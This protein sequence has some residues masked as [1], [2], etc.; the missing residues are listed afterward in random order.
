MCIALKIKILQMC[1]LVMFV[2]EFDKAE[3][4]FPIIRIIRLMFKGD[5]VIVVKCVLSVNLCDHFHK[6]RD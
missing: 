6:N 5:Y 4:F 3:K 1:I 2:N